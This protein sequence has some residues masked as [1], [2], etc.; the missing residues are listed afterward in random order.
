MDRLNRALTHPVGLAL[1]FAG[2]ADVVYHLAGRA[3]LRRAVGIRADLERW[4]G[5]R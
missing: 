2:A 4:S 1:L 3:R 5:R